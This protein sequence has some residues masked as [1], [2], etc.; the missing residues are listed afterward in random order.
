M[1]IVRLNGGLGNQMFQFAAGK[2]LA[3]QKKTRLLL[4]IS[5]FDNLPQGT[6]KRAYELGSFDI[7]AEFAGVRQIEMLARPKGI[8]RLLDKSRPYY[9]KTVYCEP[10]FHYDPNFFR[11]SSNTILAGYW[12][13][14]KYFKDAAAVIR[15]ELQV[16]APL[17][18][19][20]QALARH[21]DSV[22][23]VSIHIRRGDYVSDEKTNQYHGTCSLDYYAGALSLLMQRTSG[24]ELFVFSDEIGWAEKNLVSPLPSHFVQRNDGG[25]P[26][27]DLFLMSRCRHHIIANSS[28]SW[29]GAWLNK[30]PGKIVI[31]PSKWFNE[32]DADTKDLLPGEW[33]KV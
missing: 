8:I 5:G 29:W 18:P 11:A 3:I 21:I 24:A 7:K 13:S 22:N 17:S 31:A 23:A 26:Y 9:R 32:S 25:Q 27:E 14:E 28:F 20:T 4:D 16:K 12:Q 2:A 33:L 15:N 19:A 10:F 6:T 30:N 1:I